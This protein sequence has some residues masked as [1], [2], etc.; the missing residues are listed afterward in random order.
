[1]SLTPEQL[2]DVGMAIAQVEA[3]ISSNPEAFRYIDDHAH[4]VGDV[5]QMALAQRGLVIRA[6]PVA[7]AVLVTELEREAG[8]GPDGLN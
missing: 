1:M 7:A 3:A 8:M 5:V 6:D 2:H 4:V